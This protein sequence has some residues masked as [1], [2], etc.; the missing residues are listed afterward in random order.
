MLD[1]GGGFDAR[2]RGALDEEAEEEEE[3]GPSAHASA[4]TPVDDDGECDESG[5]ARVRG[6]WIRRRRRAQRTPRVGLEIERFRRSPTA[7]A[8]K[9]ER[10]RPDER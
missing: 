10:E 4:H 8:A 9:I 2:E 3:A 6:E 5:D 1:V 7:A